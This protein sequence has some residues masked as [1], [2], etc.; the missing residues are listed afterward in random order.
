[1]AETNHVCDVSRRSFVKGSLTA[2]VGAGAASWLTGC[3]PKPV[4]DTGGTESEPTPVVEDN[5]EIFRG[6]CRCNCYGGCYLNIHVRDGKIVRTSMRDLPETAWNRI[7]SKGLTHPYRVY[8]PNRAKYPM[9]RAGERGEGKW[10]QITW[11]EALDEIAQKFTQYAQEFG[12]DSV[13]IASG[14]GNYGFL[15]LM[16]RFQARIGASTVGTP[17]DFA[18]FYSLNPMVG[19]SLNFHGNEM[20]DLVNSKTLVIWGSNPAVSQIQGMHFIMEAREQGT[21]VISI[22]PVYTATTAKCDQWI[23]LAPGTDGMLAI[24][25]MKIVLEKGWQDDEFI[26]STTVAPFLVKEDGEYLRLSDLGRAEAGAEDDVP[27]ATDGKGTF[28]AHTAIANAVVEGTYDYQ[29]QKVT[30]AWTLMLDRLSEYDLEECSKVCDVPVDVMTQLAEDIAVN[31]PCAL[32]ILLGIDHYQNGFYSIYDMGC[33]AA[34]TGNIGKP[35][36]F[37]GISEAVYFGLE[38]AASPY[39]AYTLADATPS[40]VNVPVFRMEE[41]LEAATPTP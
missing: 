23:P 11:D 25:L 7:C 31:K 41:A 24:G 38:N 4:A 10:E 32:Y 21:K 13:G 29:G 19:M 16:P 18:P 39:G 28:D 30:C 8:D 14:A 33:L 35:G 9:R 34:M 3:S 1:M 6:T 26:R 5:D 15:D 22:D 17:L 20:T 2:A 37:C 36:A 12:P 40:T 27:V